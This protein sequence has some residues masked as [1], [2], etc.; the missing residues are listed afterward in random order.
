[1]SNIKKIYPIPKFNNIEEEDKFWQ[2]HSPLNEGYEGKAQKK[3]QNRASFLSIRLT[4]EELEYLRVKAT[5]YGLGPSTYAR[6]I[7][8]QAMETG[9]GSIPIDLIYE[10]YSLLAD[11]T[12]VQKEEY[13]QHLNEVYKTYLD[14]RYDIAEHIVTLCKPNPSDQIKEFKEFQERQTIKK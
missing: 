6:Q 9:V 8:V 12:G 2:T 5:Q 14:M 3:K 13:L 11:R 10:I 4:G 1:M 7:L